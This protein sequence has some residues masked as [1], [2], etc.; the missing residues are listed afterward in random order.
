MVRHRFCDK[1][2]ESAGNFLC[3]VLDKNSFILCH[4]IFSIK[5]I[6]SGVKANSIDVCE[7]PR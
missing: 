2:F 6:G 1:I 4:P 7:V 3:V 5:S